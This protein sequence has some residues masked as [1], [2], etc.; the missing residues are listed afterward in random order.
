MKI[1]DSI[2]DFLFP[3]KCLYCGQVGSVVCQNCVS[4]LPFPKTQI[5]PICYNP[6]L[7]G[8]THDF[9]QKRYN[10]DGLTFCFYYD[11]KI[12]EAI[13]KI[14]YRN[15]FSYVD[16]LVARGISKLDLEQ[17]KDFMII[18]VPLHEKRL[19]SRGFNQAE[20]IGKVLSGKLNI[21]LRTDILK[22][23]KDTSSQ[24]KLNKKAR[25]ENIKD[26]FTV[27]SKVKFKNMK[28][29]LVD[30]IFTSGATLN[31]CAKILKK[32]GVQKVRGFTLAHGK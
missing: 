17:F 8:K 10:L 11:D 16:E 6:S 5:C 1:L 2:L 31:E 13:K 27:N 20:I 21:Q 14:K 32:A 4:Q 24:V 28:A 7:I 9:C 29:L 23:V 22:R 30:D 18:P 26:A 19:K 12:K 3:Q 15:L 25:E